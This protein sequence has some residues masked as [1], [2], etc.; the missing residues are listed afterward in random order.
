MQ[1]LLP[2]EYPYFVV[3]DEKGNP[4]VQLRKDSTLSMIVLSHLPG[5]PSGEPFQFDDPVSLCDFAHKRGLSSLSFD[6][7]NGTMFTVST[8]EVMRHSLLD[9]STN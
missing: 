4:P 6:M 5:L 7:D 1:P 2:I 3:L 9:P 8:A